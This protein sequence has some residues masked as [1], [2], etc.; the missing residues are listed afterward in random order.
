MHFTG[1]AIKSGRSSLILCSRFSLAQDGFS[2]MHCA[3][4][5]GRLKVLKVLKELGADLNQKE[6]SG[7]TAFE[8]AALHGHHKLVGSQHA[9]LWNVQKLGVNEFPP[10]PDLHNITARNVAIHPRP[11][12]VHW[13]DVNQKRL[14]TYAMHGDLMRVRAC[15]AAGADPDAEDEKGMT[16]GALAAEKGHNDIVE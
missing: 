12:R 16:A 14:R 15:L 1:T 13:T 3:A 9:E 7:R 2:A 5:A 8:L 11:G 4:Q 6:L 10:R